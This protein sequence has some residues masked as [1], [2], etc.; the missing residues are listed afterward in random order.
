MFGITF[1]SQTITVGQSDLARLTN[2]LRVVT[3][4][5]GSCWRGEDCELDNGVRAG[6]E[7]FAAHAQTHS[8]LSEGRVRTL[9]DT[10]LEGLK[11]CFFFQFYC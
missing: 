8:Q 1:A 7:Q 9:F 6:L 11:V 5:N 3:E 2:T 10:T 4:V